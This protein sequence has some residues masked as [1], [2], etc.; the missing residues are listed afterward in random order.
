MNSSARAFRRK[1]DYIA[2][3]PNTLIKVV[4]RLFA[5]HGEHVYNHINA[6]TNN[7]LSCNSNVT[8]DFIKRHALIKWYLSISAHPNVTWDIIKKYPDYW[9][10]D[11]VSGNPNITWDIIRNN[12][13]MPWNMCVASAENASIV[14]SDVREYQM[15]NR[16]TKIRE[17]NELLYNESITLEIIETD[18]FFK[19]FNFNTPYLPRKAS[20]TLDRVLDILPNND[21][22]IKIGAKTVTYLFNQFGQNP[23]I[24]WAFIKKH[25]VDRPWEWQQIAQSIKLSIEE[26]LD[27]WNLIGKRQTERCG[28]YLSNNSNITWEMICATTDVIDWN[29]KNMA[30][31]NTNITVDVFE[32]LLQMRPQEER[33]E[34]IQKYLSNPNVTYE[35]ICAN[36]LNNL[37]H[38][39]TIARNEFL[40]DGVV[41]ARSI[42]ADIEDRRGAIKSVLNSTIGTAFDCVARY[43]D[44]A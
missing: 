26:L 39:T 36:Q 18:P 21:V 33:A 10:W 9:D 15:M 29:W 24:T 30:R 3:K 35:F 40:W 19:D 4:D 44:Y 20:V 27:F 12:P 38:I 25:G 22:I 1:R 2:S 42:K 32:Q 43:I 31:W 37:A 41:Y 28:Q 5:E 34:L 16:N 7:N 14:W 8:W 11:E 23:N 6:G 13:L 17:K